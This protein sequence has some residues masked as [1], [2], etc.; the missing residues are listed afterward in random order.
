MSPEES[1]QIYDWIMFI[2]AGCCVIFALGLYNWLLFKLYTTYNAKGE[3]PIIHRYDTKLNVAAIWILFIGTGLSYGVY[4]SETLSTCWI[5]MILYHFYC[6]HSQSMNVISIDMAD[7]APTDH[8]PKGGREK[9]SKILWVCYIPN[10]TQNNPI[11]S[12]FACIHKYIYYI[13]YPSARWDW[14]YF[15]IYN[16]NSRLSLDK[17]WIFNYCDICSC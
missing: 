11:M 2:V 7:Y 12:I 4:I 14:L 9:F 8:C 3:K 13:D 1:E 16:R 10:N 6:V 17:C 15:I 5:E